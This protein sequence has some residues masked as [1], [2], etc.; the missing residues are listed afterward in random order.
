MEDGGKLL[1][2]LVA[3]ET[4]GAPIKPNPGSLLDLADD[5]RTLDCLFQQGQRNISTHLIRLNCLNC[6][7]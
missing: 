4:A 5:E 1:E 3:V 7:S 2:P 6:P